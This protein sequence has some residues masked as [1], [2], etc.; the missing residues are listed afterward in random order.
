MWYPGRD[1]DAMRV[2]LPEYRAAAYSPDAGAIETGLNGWMASGSDRALRATWP[3]GSKCGAAP[4]SGFP[5]TPCGYPLDGGK[6]TRWSELR[7]TLL[8][9]ILPGEISLADPVADDDE[10]VCRLYTTPDLSLLLAARWNGTTASTATRIVLPQDALAQGAAHAVELDAYTLQM[11]VPAVSATPSGTAVE[12]AA[13]AGF[14][15]VLLPSPSCPSL[16]VLEPAVVPTIDLAG[17]NSTTLAL[18]LHAPWRQ[19][20]DATVAV[21]ASAPGLVLSASR[22]TVPGTLSLRVDA[23]SRFKGPAYFRLTLEANGVLPVRRWVK[24]V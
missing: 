4:L 5:S 20:G 19:A 3:Y 8:R 15:A 11:R 13:G 9:A 6:I 17:S 10:F 22:I 18:S 1:I 21:N 7:P 2:A 14:S 12:L 24:A 16:L 23:A